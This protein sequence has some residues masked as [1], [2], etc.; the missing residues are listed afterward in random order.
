M[1]DGVYYTLEPEE[2]GR[3]DT[4]SAK[5]P[6]LGVFFQSNFIHIMDGVREIPIRNQ[7]TQTTEITNKAA[8]KQLACTRSSKQQRSVGLV[9]SANS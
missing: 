4:E 8:S 5:S 2:T 7:K 6:S 3:G 9:H 1:A